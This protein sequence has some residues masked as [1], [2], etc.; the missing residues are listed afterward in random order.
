VQHFGLKLPGGHSHCLHWHWHLT[1]RFGWV[2]PTQLTRCLSST[3]D[4]SRD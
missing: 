4:G 3:S 2:G 1:L